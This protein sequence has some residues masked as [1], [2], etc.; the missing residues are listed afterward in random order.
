MKDHDRIDMID[1]NVTGDPDASE[2]RRDVFADFW[3]NDPERDH[4]DHVYGGGL[5]DRCPHH[6][7][8]ISNGVFDAPCGGCEA[9]MDP[10]D[11]SLSPEDERALRIETVAREEAARRE[12]EAVCADS[13]PF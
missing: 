5:E 1:N 12:L 3:T 13:I 10:E 6:G 9:A 11:E 2:D 7:E 4:W 8:V